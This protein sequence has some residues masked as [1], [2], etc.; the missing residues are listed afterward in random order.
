MLNKKYWADGSSIKSMIMKITA[1][2]E[3]KHMSDD[4]KKEA[5][6]P[7]E[8]ALAKDVDSFWKCVMTNVKFSNPALVK[9]SYFYK[10]L[11]SGHDTVHDLLS[12]D[13]NA[14]LKFLFWKS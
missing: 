4:W 3:W 13:V 2:P 8:K 5:A 14:I 6:K 10:K 12:G 1:T 9:G 7:N 11:D